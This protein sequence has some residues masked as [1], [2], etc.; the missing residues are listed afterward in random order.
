MIGKALLRGA[1]CHR[2]DWLRG[3]GAGGDSAGAAD[4]GASD[5][6]GD[7][8]FEAVADIQ[9]IVQRIDSIV[10]GGRTYVPGDH[11]MLDVKYASFADAEARRPDRPR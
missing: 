8:S 9:L 4:S 10:Y 1:R 7:G 5:D 6:P 3:A 11:L 2:A